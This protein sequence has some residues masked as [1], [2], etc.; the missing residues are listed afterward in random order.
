MLRRG[1]K[2]ISPDAEFGATLLE[3]NKAGS[4]FIIKYWKSSITR[5]HDSFYPIS[6]SLPPMP[7]WLHFHP[8]NLEGLS[9]SKLGKEAFCSNSIAL[10]AEADLPKLAFEFLLTYGFE[11]FYRQ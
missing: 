7:E 6:W 5:E 10:C 9:D 2:E 8:P 11:S 4:N 3:V 1:L